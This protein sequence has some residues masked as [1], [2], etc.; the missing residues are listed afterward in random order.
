MVERPDR[1]DLLYETHVFCCANVRPQGHPRGCCSAR[2]SVELRD[3]MKARAKELGLVLALHSYV[4]EHGDKMEAYGAS[5]WGMMH[6]NRSALDLGI[7]VAGNSDFPVSAADPLL[8][9]Q[10]MVT[11]TS[12][13]GKVYGEEQRVTPEEA[14]QF[15]KW[16]LGAQ[17]EHFEQPVLPSEK[18]CLEVF[19]EIREMGVPVAVDESLFSLDQARR[20]IEE[21]AVDVGVI[22]IAKFGGALAARE[23]AR[24]DATSWDPR[25]ARC[26][27]PRPWL[28]DPS[29]RSGARPWTTSIRSSSRAIVQE[30]RPAPSR[31]VAF[32]QS[33]HDQSHSVRLRARKEMPCT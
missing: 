10:S 30:A 23:V 4:Y 26:R 20:L 16:T 3:Y 32:E 18:D 22:K 5:G 17:I 6:A 15:C 27:A 8:R 28:P 9:I 24:S 21:D 1:Q 2:G 31:A 7:P 25:R 19:R 13:E 29:R 33:M 12:A 14:I 11:R